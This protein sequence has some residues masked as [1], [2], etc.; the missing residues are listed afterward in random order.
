MELR[1]DTQWSLDVR[2][3]GESDLTWWLKTSHLVLQM[4]FVSQFVWCLVVGTPLKATKSKLLAGD[5]RIAQF[6]LFGGTSF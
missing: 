6:G 3:P 4:V 2:V 1:R 5:L